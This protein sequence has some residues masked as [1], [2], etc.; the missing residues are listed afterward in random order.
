MSTSQEY[1]LK[2]QINWWERKRWVYNVVLL[3]ICLLAIYDVMQMMDYK[4][5]VV[6]FIVI[7]VWALGANVFY[8]SGLLLLP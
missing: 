1:N 3:V 5:S 6:D 8:S 7:V 4:W 2:P